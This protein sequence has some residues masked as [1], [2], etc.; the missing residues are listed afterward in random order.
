MKIPSEKG[1]SEY[2]H[3]QNL[4]IFTYTKHLLNTIS[5][6]QKVDIKRAEKKKIAEFSW[7]LVK[8]ILLQPIK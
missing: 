7:S 3:N 5:I 8:S 2:L 1:V 6:L 4:L